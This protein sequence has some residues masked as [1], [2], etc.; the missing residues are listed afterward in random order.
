MKD[1]WERSF[2]S[3]GVAVNQEGLGREKKEEAAKF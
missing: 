3:E 1:S 2:R